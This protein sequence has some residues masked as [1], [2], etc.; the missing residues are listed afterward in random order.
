MNSK[1]TIIIGIVVLIIVIGL[2]F[3]ASKVSGG[4]GK[5]DGF[6]QCLNDK[7]AKFYGAFW[8][9]HCQNQK[10]LFGSSKRYLPYIECSTQDIRGQLEICTKAGIAGY[11]TWIFADMSSSTGELSLDTLSQKTG[12][13]LPL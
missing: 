11:P 12:C 13:P 2:L 1:K 9:S 7:G 4:P 10:A 8:C 6:A 3:Y 5:L